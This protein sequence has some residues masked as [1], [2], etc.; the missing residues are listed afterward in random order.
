MKLASLLLLGVTLV[1]FALL[2]A[3]ASAQQPAPGPPAPVAPAPLTVPAEVRG[4]VGQP[5][6]IR[7]ATSAE[8]VRYYPMTP[9]LLI[10][11]SDLLRDPRACVCWAHQPG[12]Y[13]VLCYASVDGKATEPQIVTVIVTVPPAPG[14]TPAP[15]G[16]GPMPPAPARDPLTDALQKLYDADPATAA[17]KA[18]QKDVLTGLYQAMQSASDAGKWSTVGEARKALE[19]AAKGM[20]LGPELLELR[21]RVAA[22]VG[23]AWGAAPDAKISDTLRARVSDTYGRIAAAL[24]AVK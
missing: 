11:P 13:D 5:I 16:P 8:T 10:F 4:P 20:G 15:P 2:P 19:T 7:P 12:R 6:T 1:L 9:G 18:K 17:A 24:A 14:P 23:L 21:R 22:E 3:L